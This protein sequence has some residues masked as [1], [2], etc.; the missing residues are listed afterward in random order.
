MQMVQPYLPSSSPARP[1]HPP[2]AFEIARPL[3]TTPVRDGTSARE[4][5]ADFRADL[6]AV[7]PSL[8]A[9]ALSLVGDR[10]R[11]DDLVQDTLLRALQKQDRFEPDTKLQAWLFTILRNLFYSDYR[12]RKR[13]VED[14]DGLYAAKLSTLPEQPGCAEFETLRSAL[15]RLSDEQREAV[16]LVGAQGYSYEQVAEICGAPL[17]TI[18]SR[19]NRARKRLAELLKH[20]HDSEHDSDVGPDGVMQAALGPRMG[21]VLA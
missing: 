15:A 14:V 2:P 17:G 3:P 12:R 11:A 4:R 5:E 20:E 21:G 1:L 8:R 7:T 16:L 9:F 19:V 6:L 10:D 18:K 13:E